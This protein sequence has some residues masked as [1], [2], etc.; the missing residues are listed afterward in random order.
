MRRRPTLAAATAVLA[1]LAMA[2]G[3]A[4]ARA[5]TH[6]GN[7]DRGYVIDGQRVFP[8]GV[9]AA[10]RFVYAT[11]VA[12]GT[13]YRGDAS[14]D[15]LEPFVPGG[16]DGRSTATG[17]KSFGGRLLVAG[18]E[19]GRFYIYDTATKARVATYTVPEPDR[20]SFPLDEIVAPNGDV[21]IHGHRP[22]GHLSHSG[23]R[24]LR[25][26]DRSSTHPAARDL[27]LLRATPPASMPTASWLPRT[28]ERCWSS[29]PKAR[30]C[31]GLTS[32]QEPPDGSPWT[33][34][35]LR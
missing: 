3:A 12:D 22:A 15:T 5:T 11:S 7:H 35:C 21:Y 10:E 25:A 1:V 2:A 33:A 31:T 19:T 24:S 32:R 13:V 28:G 14:G 30:P 34:P 18:A 9:A 23:T 16:Q 8:E 29:I 20:P 4:P 27:S 6:P 26:P 17:I